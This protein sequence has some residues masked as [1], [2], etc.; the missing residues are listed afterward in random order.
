MKAW[1]QNLVQKWR[2]RRM[3]EA[4]LAGSNGMTPVFAVLAF[5][6]GLGPDGGFVDAVDGWPVEGWPGDND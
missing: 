1:W 4:Y 6:S 3:P 2:R 5:D